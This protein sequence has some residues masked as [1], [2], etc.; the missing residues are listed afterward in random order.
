MLWKAIW[1]QRECNMSKDWTKT[2][3][4][5]TR[6]EL[7]VA[8]GVRWKKVKKIIIIIESM[9]HCYQL[10]QL[11]KVHVQCEGE[12]SERHHLPSG[13]QATDSALHNV[14]STS[15]GL[16]VSCP[17]TKCNEWQPT[18]HLGGQRGN[19]RTMPLPRE[20]CSGTI[21]PGITWM[22]KW[23]RLGW[24]QALFSVGKIYNITSSSYT[25][26]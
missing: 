9:I 14:E 7:P 6:R 20:I 19:D 18:L 3:Q 13:W 24:H 12:G 21:W 23:F 4:L 1:E 10:T 11:A 5:K 26:A 22:E 25:S 2:M 15:M 8:W 16:R 17:R